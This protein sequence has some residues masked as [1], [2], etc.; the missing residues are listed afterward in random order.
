MLISEAASKS[1]L[2]TETIR[3]YE[4][5]GIVPRVE[6]LPNGNRHFTT[7]NVE[8]LTLLYW[9][10]K[11]GMP[12][13]VMQHFAKLYNQGDHTIPERKKILLEHQSRLEE[14]RNNIDQCSAIL[15]H[16]LEIYRRFES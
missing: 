1:G 3:Y 7:E 11:T 16:K 12:I 2:S 10:R 14:R 8:W 9:L 4:T 15:S 13:K 5:V 6:R